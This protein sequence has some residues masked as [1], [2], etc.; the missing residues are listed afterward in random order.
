VLTKVSNLPTENHENGT[1]G[2][3]FLPFN[4]STLVVHEDELFVRWV[5]TVPEEGIILNEI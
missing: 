1:A 3:G 4:L 5:V 2:Y